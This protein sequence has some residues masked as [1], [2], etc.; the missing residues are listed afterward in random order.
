MIKGNNSRIHPES[1]KISRFVGNIFQ[2][3]F[4]FIFNLLLFAAFMFA[5]IG[6][7]F[8]YGLGR[9]K[10]LFITKPFIVPVLI[11][12]YVLNSNNVFALI[13]IALICAFLGD[14][15][16]MWS[17]RRIYFISGMI[18]F[19]IMH[20]LFIIFILN[21]QIQ[22]SLLALPAH[23]MSLVYLLLGGMVFVLLYKNLHEFKIP[24]VFYILALLGLSYFC[25]INVIVHK[26]EIAFAQYLGSLLF[27]ISD[28]MLAIVCFR[29]P[30]RNCG[31]LVAAT[32]I[33]AM[34]FLIAGFMC[35]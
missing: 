31:I 13:V 19:F 11:G 35:C 7:L 15:F 16:L 5:A 14:V 23:L 17:H 32:Y 18:A 30:F 20:I 27:I 9:R 24:I 34:I 6:T 21:Y 4:K 3:D 10:L 8:S 25:F 2:L 12:F 22:V 1:E 26:S 29:K 28:F 33:L